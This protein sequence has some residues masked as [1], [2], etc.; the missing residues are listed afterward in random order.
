MKPKTRAYRIIQALAQDSYLTSN[1]LAQQMDVSSRTI[2]RD[3]KRINEMNGKEVISS[4]KGK[5]YAL[6]VDIDDILVSFDYDD[7]S[8]IQRRNEIALELLFDAPMSITTHKLFDNYFLSTSVINSDLAKIENKLKQFGLTLHRSKDKRIKVEGPEILIRKAIYRMLADTRSDIIS[9]MNEYDAKFVTSVVEEVENNLGSP[10][11]YPYNV[12]LVSHIY[13]VIKRYRGVSNVR[14]YQIEESPIISIDE[15]ITNAAQQIV[16]RIEGYLGIKLPSYE[17]SYIA[18]YL[19]SSRI[20]S[21]NVEKK[22]ANKVVRSVNTIINNVC[23]STSDDLTTL[24]RDLLAHF[25]P[26]LNRILNGI[27][28]ENALLIDIESE[29]P[30]LFKKVKESVNRVMLLEYG[31]TLSD[32]EIGF[33][34]LYFAKFEE[35]NPKVIRVV[36]LCSSGVG[37]SELLKVKLERAFPSTIEVID[38]LSWRQYKKRKQKLEGKYD[39]IITTVVFEDIDEDKPIILVNAMLPKNDIQRI[40]SAIKEMD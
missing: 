15:K 20:T 1:D 24:K 6:S 10:I 9:D 37:T 23:S 36:V 14:N 16:N 22:V 3:I 29:Y 26:M 40:E 4:K 32:N 38:V 34:V 27:E 13:I 8:P 12:N 11:P 21:D 18:Q 39:M 19:I 2:I 7:Y 31:M 25:E 28:V 30:I 35:M 17:K 5:G 33:I